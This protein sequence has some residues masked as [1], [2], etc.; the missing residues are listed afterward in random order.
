M[1][2]HIGISNSDS[3]IFNFGLLHFCRLKWPN[4]SP[5]I[6]GPFPNHL[7]IINIIR[8]PHVIVKAS[9]D[10]NESR[11]V[12]ITT[13]GLFDGLEWV[14]GHVALPDV[15]GRTTNEI[16]Q[17]GQRVFTGQIDFLTI[18]ELAGHGDGAAG[19]DGLIYLDRYK[20]L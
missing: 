1:H 14:V 15:I 9:L 2:K 12:N 13:S 11:F 17:L 6:T 3:K 20:K 7:T 19:F 16:S 10:I 8:K 5:R 18:F 4:S